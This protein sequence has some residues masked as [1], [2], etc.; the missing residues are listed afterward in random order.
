MEGAPSN[1]KNLATHSFSMVSPGLRVTRK[2]P[3][4][5]TLF[6]LYI[7]IGLAPLVIS[8][9]LGLDTLTLNFALRLLKRDVS[10]SISEKSSIAGEL[11]ITV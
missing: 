3:P 5:I 9:S 1:G 2:L 10:T 8:T 7:N 6:P 11:L 4:T